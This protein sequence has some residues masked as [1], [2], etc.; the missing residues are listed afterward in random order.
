MLQKALKHGAVKCYV[1]NVEEEFAIQ[2]FNAVEIRESNG[3]GWLVF[4]V[5]LVG[6]GVGVG[7][8]VA[9]ETQSAMDGFMEGIFGTNKD[10]P[11]LSHQ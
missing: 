7:A 1:D 2:D 11:I 10:G 6:V 4:A 5:V 9:A 8:V 3:T